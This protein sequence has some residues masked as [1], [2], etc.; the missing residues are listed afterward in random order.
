VTAPPSPLRARLVLAGAVVA[1]L[2]AVTQRSSLGVAGV[3]AA[4]RFDVTAAAL[5]TLGVLQLAVY[6]VLQVPVGVLV[7]R[8]GPKVVITTGAVLMIAGQVVVAVAP[9]LPA[10]VAGRMLVGAGDATTFV[11][12]LRLVNVW[13][14]PRRVP[15]MT[16]WLGNLGQL[17]QV[18]SL[19]PFAALL[20][21]A[22]WTPAFLAAAGLSG[23]A[24]VVVL[25]LVADA[26]GGAVPPDLRTALAS[27]RAAA[28]RPG[29]RLGFWAHFVT[30]SSGV[31]FA[32]FWGY[33]YLVRAVG[34]DPSI[35]SLLLSL[36]VL[37][38]FLVGPVLGVLTA[39]FPFR[40]SNLVLGIVGVMAIAWTL[41][42]AW[43]GRPPIVLIVLLLLTLGV[44]GPASQIGFDYARTFN[45]R[46]ALGGA[47]GLVNVGGFTASFS[48]MFLIGLVLDL[49][50]RA[51]G[52]PLYSVEAFRGAFAVQYLVV[53]LGV[54]A[55]LVARRSTRRD[56][57]ATE[58][59]V[60]GP[61]WIAY[62][63]WLRR[64]ALARRRNTPSSRVQL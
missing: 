59:I 44:G 7:D 20:H 10:A 49:E 11:A 35:A 9:V 39:R 2:C 15:V 53:G 42:L 52:V 25:V 29:T 1:Y 57:Q 56:L 63:H 16:Q 58:G 46:S 22:G 43:P 62:G 51:T 47:S 54:A 64:R 50:H 12:A 13:F 30:Q 36:Q 5:S 14:P 26:P 38:G 19:V 34:V 27:L 60:V 37:S 24:L 40:R 18:L 4:T 55:L 61:V 3:A 28:A 8:Y 48:M 6:A 41:V 32:L 21:L 45:P 17:G 33:P 23:V 31:V